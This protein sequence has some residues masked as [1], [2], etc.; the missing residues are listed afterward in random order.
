MCLPNFTVQPRAVNWNEE[1]SIMYIDN[2][3]R[4][5]CCSLDTLYIVVVQCKGNLTHVRRS[6][7]GKIV[8]HVSQTDR[9]TVTFPTT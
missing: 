3:V 8:H 1:Y 2:P 4:A 7:V 9:N 5:I 6:Q